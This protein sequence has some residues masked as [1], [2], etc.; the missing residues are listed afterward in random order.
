MIFHEYQQFIESIPLIW[1]C[2]GQENVA[3][4]APVATRRPLREL[5]LQ[6]ENGLSGEE[7]EATERVENLHNDMTPMRM[8]RT[9]CGIYGLDCFV[10][11]A[12]CVAESS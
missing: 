9:L 3:N 2:V 5:Q 7:R 12:I 10:N 4:V 11:L 8:S 1:S 6:A